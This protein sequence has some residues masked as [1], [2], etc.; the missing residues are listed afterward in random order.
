MTD[1]LDQL[2]FRFFKLFAQ[3]ESALKEQGLFAELRGNISVNWDN[4]ANE[5]VGKTFLDDLG[6]DRA[7]A[8]YILAQ[9]PKR[10]AVNGHQE[11]RLGRGS[12]R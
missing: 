3:Y 4:F 10:Q 12:S 2:A 7:A 11:N 6:T 8:E 9:P 5:R 1:E